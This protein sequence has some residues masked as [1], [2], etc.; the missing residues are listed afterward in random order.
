M[1]SGLEE[2]RIH[3]ENGPG[4]MG[5]SGATKIGEVVGQDQM[6]VWMFC[7][8]TQTINGVTTLKKINHTFCASIPSDTLNINQ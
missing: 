5:K 3:L 8:F 7:A 2:K 6:K 1:V 4:Q